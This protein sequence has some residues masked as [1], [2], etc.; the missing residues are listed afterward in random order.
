[1]QI[2]HE[3][4][5][6]I[7]PLVRTY[8]DYDYALV[9]LFEDEEIGKPYFDFFAESLNQGR[10]VIL[11]NS[12]FELGTAFEPLKFIDWVKKLLPTEYI[13]PDVFRNSEATL[14]KVDE[15]F[16]LLEETQSTE[17]LT[18]CKAIAVVQGD[19]FEDC[20]DCYK[21]LLSDKRIYKIAI[22]FDFPWYQ[23]W[24]GLT[25]KEHALMEGRRRFMDYLHRLN[26]PSVWKPFHLL[27]CALPQEFEYYC[28]TPWLKEQ[29]E[30]I[31]TSNPVLHGWLGIK[32]E[33]HGL[34]QKDLTKMAT[35]IKEPCSFEKCTDI[36]YNIGRFKG[37]CKVITW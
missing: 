32:Y 19:S 36:V 13:I 23:E 9:H 11:D 1:M 6:A 35:I 31:D 8:T 16:S 17:V 2:A 37:F 5:L 24:T 15:W 20:V 21:K 22:P 10:R 30:T 33:T 26:R 29:I 34:S 25:N 7:M 12:I 18:K 4:P 14:Q 3:A 27:G 28:N